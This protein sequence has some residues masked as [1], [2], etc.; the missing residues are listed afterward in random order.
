[1]GDNNKKSNSYRDIKKKYGFI[2]GDGSNNSSTD[3]RREERANAPK[4][5]PS[6]PSRKPRPNSQKKNTRKRRPSQDENLDFTRI[7]SPEMIERERQRIEMERKKARAKKIRRNRMIFI[8]GVIVVILLIVLIV[9]SLASGGTQVEEKPKETEEV[10]EEKV[11]EE[12]GMI[13]K[14]SVAI[15]TTDIYKDTKENEDRES[16]GTVPTAAYVKNYGVNGDY[17]RIAYQDKVGYVKTSDLEDAGEEKEFKVIN[18]VLLVNNDYSLPSDYDPGI[19]EEAQKAFDIMLAT[20]KRDDIVLK[21]ASDYRNYEQQSKISG[22]SQN[23]Y[24][25]Y[26]NKTSKS[27]KAGESEHQTGLAFDIMGED[28]DNKYDTNFGN[29]KEAKWLEENAY[30]SGFILR[31][32]KGKEDITGR[33]YEPWHYRFVGVENATKIYE[34]KITME[35][36]LDVVE[37]PVTED[38]ENSN[39]KN[40]NQQNNGNVEDKS[41]EENQ[42]NNQNTDQ[43]T[44][45]NSNRE[46]NSTENKQNNQTNKNNQNNSNSQNSSSNK[47]KNN[48]NNN[49]NKNNSS[50]NNKNTGNNNQSNSSNKNTNSK[51]SSNKQ[52]NEQSSSNK[53]QNSN[54]NN[55]N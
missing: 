15:K 21:S 52:N 2:S 51:N 1:M 54:N 26:D 37:E 3:T 14:F 42:D 17:T 45:E 48:S 6:A 49:S 4:Q 22:Q 9:K 8:G 20:A 32:P 35:E 34:E 46:D 13:Q 31:Y 23:K 43:K 41:K 18:G 39:K 12:V 25:E 38:T 24:G 47:E 11:T 16:I 19:D 55:N 33:A 44:E 7:L 36:F 53:T 28:Y 5:R 50:N 27:V 29:S 40:D 30:K 10:V